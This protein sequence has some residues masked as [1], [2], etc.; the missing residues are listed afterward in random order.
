MFRAILCLLLVL[1]CA[2]GGAGAPVPKHLMPKDTA[3][4]WQKRESGLEVMDVKV[5]AGDPVKPGATVVVHY[6]GWLTDEKGT[7]FDSSRDR[8]PPAEFPLNAVI[9]GWQEGVPGMKPG[10]VR[11][12]K[13]P[14]NLAY[15]ER[16]AG[17]TVPPNAVL[18]FE[19]E[20]VET[21]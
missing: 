19:I 16:G 8:G 4:T 3:G 21:K 1:A 13:I 5:G 6:T 2:A 7:K 12:L 9:K 10:G 14:A 18:V 17:A 15:G 11:K 20:L